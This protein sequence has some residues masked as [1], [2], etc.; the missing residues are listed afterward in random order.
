M[1][2][3]A[4]VSLSLL[5]IPSLAA[6]E[7]LDCRREVA[8]AR[9]LFQDHSSA[10]LRLAAPLASA[11]RHVLQRALTAEDEALVVA[12]GRGEVSATALDQRLWPKLRP[13]FERFERGGCR[14]LGGVVAAQ[15]AKVDVCAVRPGGTLHTGVLVSCARAP[16]Q[17]ETRRHIGLHVQRD[18]AGVRV[19]LR[20]YVQTRMSAD[21]SPDAADWKG[22]AVDV[23]L[24]DRAQAVAQLSAALDAF[25]GAES[26]FTWAVPASCMERVS[27]AAP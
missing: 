22:F 2:C 27:V 5:M 26:D 3:P 13:V 19:S 10:R 6:S 8:E 4:L 1:R 16:L 24:S 18:E 14:E 21:A 20:G 11:V 15:D 25:T 12:F 23:P 9:Q 7:G 17:G